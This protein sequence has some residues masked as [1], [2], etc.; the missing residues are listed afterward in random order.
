[1][2]P[3]L[4]NPGTLGDLQGVT[5]NVRIKSH[6]SLIYHSWKFIHPFINLWD[7]SQTA[8]LCWSSQRDKVQE[9]LFLQTVSSTAV[10]HHASHCN[11]QWW[12]DG[13]SDALT[14]C[15][16]PTSAPC[17]H[18]LWRVLIIPWTLLLLTRSEASL[19]VQKLPVIACLIPASLISKSTRDAAWCGR[20][21]ASDTTWFSCRYILHIQEDLS[22]SLSAKCV[23]FKLQE[24][25][26]IRNQQH[27]ELLQQKEVFHHTTLNLIGKC[28][29]NGKVGYSLWLNGLQAKPF[30]LFFL[31]R[32]SSFWRPKLMQS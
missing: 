31:E 25:G 27:T 15:F 6:R 1:M 29:S 20:E 32:E 10:R 8:Y 7:P 21:S 14:D 26:L 22:C 17:W 12:S 24:T 3:W 18:A 28:T 19:L 2:E 4:L 30:C 9:R 23:P 16:F 11:Q 5:S 13:C